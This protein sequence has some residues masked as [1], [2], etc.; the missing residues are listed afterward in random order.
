VVTSRLSCNRW[1]SLWSASI[2]MRESVLK[3][4]SQRVQQ[5]NAT[6]AAH[7]L[8]PCGTLPSA[9][10]ARALPAG[11]V[12][13]NDGMRSQRAAT[14]TFSRAASSA[15]HAPPKVTKYR[16]SLEYQ[17]D[18][19]SQMEGVCVRKGCACSA[20]VYSLCRCGVQGSCRTATSGATVG[21][22]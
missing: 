21:R 19:R 5:Q 20:L 13:T 14:V 2:A 4:L 6:S 15:R 17:S 3:R 16:Q 10:Q 7:R 22:R 18:S 1:Q 11:G 12:E 9:Q 8:L